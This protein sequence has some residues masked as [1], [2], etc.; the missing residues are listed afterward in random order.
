LAPPTLRLDIVLFLLAGLLLG[1]PVVVALIVW[2]VLR[3]RSTGATAADHPTCG[4][5]GAGVRGIGSLTCPECGADLREAGIQTPGGGLRPVKAA[6]IAGA[7]T[8][9]CVLVALAVLLLA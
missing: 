5:C 3:M 4:K 2:L 6:A 7:V 1:L 9:G 8:L